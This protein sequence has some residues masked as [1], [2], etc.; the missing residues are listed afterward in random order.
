MDD[1]PK[2]GETIGG[3]V[4]QSVL[5]R[6]GM[7][8]V[9][10]G[11]HHV[12]GRKAAIKV[13]AGSLASDKQFVSRFFHEAKIVND[14]RHSNIVDITDF[15]QSAEPL[16]VA[17]IMEFIDGD[18]ISGALKR[19][20][21]SS[22]QAVNL[23]LQ[24]C[25][26][27]AAVHEIGVVHRDLKPA[28]IML[29]APVTSDFSYPGSIKVVDF[30]IAKVSDP[31]TDHQTATG[32][33]MGTP[34]YM[35]PEQVAGLKITAAADVYAVAEILYELLAGKPV[36]SGNNLIVMRNKL[37]TT[38]PELAPLDGHAQGDRILALVNECL[39][40][41]ASD[42]PSLPDMQSRLRDLVSRFS[43]VSVPIATPRPM[44][45]DGFGDTLLRDGEPEP[46]VAPQAEEVREAA[47]AEVDAAF[48]TSANSLVLSPRG[49]R[50]RGLAL[51]G[52]LLCAVAVGVVVWVSTQTSAPVKVESVATVPTPTAPL[53]AVAPAAPARI[54]VHVSTSPLASVL[55]ENSKELGPGPMDIEVEP[56]Q[57]RT[58]T[59][60]HPARESVTVQIDG[61]KPVVDVWLPPKAKTPAPSVAAKP[62]REATP[63][64]AAKPNR[65]PTPQVE[66]S[67]EAKALLEAKPAPVAK[68][69]LPAKPAPVPEP[70]PESKPAAAEAVGVGRLAVDAW[71]TA[72][73]RLPSIVLVDG[74]QVST[75]TPI[76]IRV[77]EGA[78]KIEVRAPGYPPRFRTVQ[79]KANQTS[80]L[81]IVVDL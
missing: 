76:D 12:L 31:D 57:T 56:G 39:A 71:T 7:G 32:A 67:A 41:E 80:K 64:P 34:A 70:Q 18:S 62:T 44:S 77:R 3:Y 63:A 68:P 79:V 25:D 19:H 53:E 28:N 42:R 30:G 11:S 72:G 16:R 65:D 69:A 4:L 45:V 5:G 47:F 26:A 50:R 10:L 74:K 15:V 27:L 2:I 78:R 17:Y 20:D 48:S 75:N 81:R 59:I 46:S 37:G 8:C 35:A 49:P 22:L 21:F 36:F 51:I 29:N 54:K 40:V 73:R 38:P 6:G 43:D 66:L 55:F 14:V 9:Y 13:L 1:S 61:T 33:V 60:E 24:I 52:L 58:V 23:C